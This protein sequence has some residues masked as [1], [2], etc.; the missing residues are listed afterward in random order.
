[1]ELSD[2]EELYTLNND[3]N[4]DGNGK[5]SREERA[6]NIIR[7]LFSED[8]TDMQ[9]EIFK[10]L[11]KKGRTSSAKYI[12]FENQDEVRKNYIQTIGLDKVISAIML[13]EVDPSVKAISVKLDGLRKGDY[14]S[15]VNS[16]RRQR[17]LQ[18][19]H[20][21]YSLSRTGKIQRDFVRSLS[22]FEKDEMHDI[23]E[24]RY[25]AKLTENDVPSM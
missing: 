25:F 1:M 8:S 14:V 10:G 12:D 13:M 9:L 4:D 6:Y 3:F 22:Q 24:E 18:N 19:I 5:L 7:P 2:I 15:C 21:L 17:G 23:L 16:M 20:Q 11:I